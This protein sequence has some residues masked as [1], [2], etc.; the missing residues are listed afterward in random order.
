[1]SFD[2]NW[3]QGKLASGDEN[4]RLTAVRTLLSLPS[5]DQEKLPRLIRVISERGMADGS[6]AVRY[7]AKK[8]YDRLQNLQRRPD[9]AVLRPSLLGEQAVNAVERAPTLV[10][11]TREYW[12]YELRSIDFKIRVKAVM[13]LCRSHRDDAVFQR[14]L[15]MFGEDDH[16]HVLATLGKYL[17]LFGRPEILDEALRLLEHRDARVRANT[18]EGLEELGSDLAV[19]AVMPLLRDTDNRVRAN[20]AKFLVTM[21]PDEVRATLQEMLGSDEEWMRDSAIY[22]LT[23]VEVPGREKLLLSVLE[24]ASSDIARKALEALA[25]LPPSAAIRDCL[26]RLSHHEGPLTN[27]ASE[28]LQRMASRVTDA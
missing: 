23:R 13:E 18:I 26:E 11:G 6:I 5:F 25:T 20:A 22:I 7:Y 12:L 3:L 2:A 27:M 16:E 28:H 9:L 21:S 17:A 1:M 14:L 10:Y 24:D 4:V 8:A 19:P 15:A